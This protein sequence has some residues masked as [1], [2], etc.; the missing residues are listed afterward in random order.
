MVRVATNQTPQGL[1]IQTTHGLPTPDAT[2]VPVVVPQILRNPN[3][4]PEGVDYTGAHGT[5]HMHGSDGKCYFLDDE[6]PCDPARVAG[7]N[8]AYK[9]RLS[10]QVR[11]FRE[12]RCSCYFVSESDEEDG[13][14]TGDCIVKCEYCVW[15][16]CQH[17]LL[18]HTDA[19]DPCVS[20]PEDS[21]G[22]VEE[23]KPLRFRVLGDTGAS[24][25]VEPAV[26]TE[27]LVQYCSRFSPESS[28]AETPDEDDD[29]SSCT[30][31]GDDSDAEASDKEN[32]PPPSYTHLSKLRSQ[33]TQLTV[34]RDEYKENWTQAE[35]EKHQALDYVLKFGKAA[36][37]WQNYSEATDETLDEM[38]EHLQTARDSVM[39]CLSDFSPKIAKIVEESPLQDQPRIAAKAFHTLVLS[40]ADMIKR[41]RSKLMQRQRK[42]K[43]NTAPVSDF[44]ME[45]GKGEW[46]D[47][48]RGCENLMTALTARGH[49]RPVRFARDLR[50]K[51]GL[52]QRQL[53]RR[54]VAGR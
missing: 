20:S 22:E 33:V 39:N 13:T 3:F 30:A 40:Q 11:K 54:K 23:I 26:K 14:R 21:D 2:P 31:S 35:A 36:K 12:K 18:V 43:K 17:C 47:V 53:P 45:R 38:I 42:Q 4:I 34:Q 9:I 49:S 44:M 25:C 32:I 8:V 19:Q 16:Q 1:S 50:V 7:F 48:P 6:E 51:N 24:F 27:G 28:D 37:S 15:N 41:L 29:D 5:Q 52:L 46:V 10:E